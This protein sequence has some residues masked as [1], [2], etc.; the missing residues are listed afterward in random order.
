[1][2]APLPRLQRDH[3][4]PEHQRLAG[5]VGNWTTEGEAGENP[6]GPPEKWSGTITSE[7]FPGNFAVVRHMKGKGSV[8]GEGLGLNVIA[9]DAAAKVYT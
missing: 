4:A 7:W 5:L 6:F 1:V 3:D 2:S 8:S 9:Y